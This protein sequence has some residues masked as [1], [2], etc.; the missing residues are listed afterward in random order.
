MY[1]AFDMI[2]RK[3]NRS[4]PQGGVPV[5]VSTNGLCPRCGTQ[6]YSSGDHYGKYLEC[7]QCGYQQDI[8]VAKPTVPKSMQG[9]YLSGGRPPNPEYMSEGP[10]KLEIF[11]VWHGWAKRPERC[12]E[13]GCPHKSYAPYMRCL[14]HTT[15]LGKR[16]WKRERKMTRRSEVTIFW[17]HYHGDKGGGKVRAYIE[18]IK[19]TGA[20]ISYYGIL[21]SPHQ[22]GKPSGRLS[23]WLKV[24]FSNEVRLPAMGIVK[25]LKEACA[26]SVARQDI[27]ASGG[28]ARANS[29]SPERRSEIGRMGAEATNRLRAER[30]SK[31]D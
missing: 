19:I 1:S 26:R 3:G 13:D 18:R 28:Y 7:L 16:F 17:R 4:G 15:S 22:S 21:S 25:P 11:N 2:G 12:I 6:L 20:S 30:R 31:Y 29:L 14:A 10:A 23:Q 9:G 8:V 5:P 27:S 24:A